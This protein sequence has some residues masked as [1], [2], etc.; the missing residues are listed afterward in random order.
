VSNILSADD[1][2]ERAVPAVGIPVQQL[3]RHVCLKLSTSCL[4]LRLSLS[5]RLG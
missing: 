3:K 1:G 2:Q 5:L 4:G